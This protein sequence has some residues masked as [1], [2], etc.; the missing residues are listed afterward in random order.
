M[1]PFT[2]LFCFILV[3]SGGI[4]Y[5]IFH[6]SQTDSILMRYQD[7]LSLSDQ[8]LSYKTVF[9]SWDGQGLV[10]H[11]PVFPKLPIRMQT[12]RLG[13]NLSKQGISFRLSGIIADIA[14]TLTEQKNQ[15]LIHIFQ[16]FNPPND[17][18]MKP[19]ATMA[20]LKQDIFNGNLEITLQPQNNFIRFQAC[21]I[22]NKK[23]II[24]FQS[25]LTPVN[26]KKK[27][28]L[29]N[30]LSYPFDKGSVLISDIE[31]LKAVAG[32]YQSIQKTIPTA[33]QEAIVASKPLNLTFNLTNPITLKTIF[34]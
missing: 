9:R 17:F 23:E 15:D 10:F 13:I 29:S 25:F 20:L 16:S 1:K 26:T 6:Q 24:R 27:I 5:L 4:V 31:L 32:Y 8:E 14:K 3:L 12:D 18:L 28:T 21:L 11:Q 30:W 19:L 34:E 2:F 7:E 22:R 33:L